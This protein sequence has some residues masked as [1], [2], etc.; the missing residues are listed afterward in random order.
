MG[1]RNKCETLEY[2]DTSQTHNTGAA[3][4]PPVSHSYLHRLTLMSL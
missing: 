1:T 2:Y 3:A 4:K